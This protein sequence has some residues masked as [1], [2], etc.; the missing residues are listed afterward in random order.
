MQSSCFVKSFGTVFLLTILVS[1]QNTEKEEQAL[2]EVCQTLNLSAKDFDG[3]AAGKLRELN[4]KLI[5][6][7]LKERAEIWFPKAD[8]INKLSELSVK[9]I[10][11]LQQLIT[12]DNFE[13]VVKQVADIYQSY[14]SKVLKT[15]IEI[16]K[17]FQS[18][19]GKNN[20]FQNF[21][22]HSLAQLFF[23]KVKHDISY[24]NERTIDY[25]NIKTPPGCILDFT[26]SQTLVGQS[27]TILLPGEMLEISAGVGRFSAASKPQIKINK[28]N[29]STDDNPVATTKIKVPQK[30]GHYTV[31]VEISYIDENGETI[32]QDYNIKYKVANLQE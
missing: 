27:S 31:P 20:N 18:E 23:Y 12:K 1:C 11:S 7:R 15:D 17:V 32:T 28:R 10:D 5:D 9:Q 21:N 8:T 24:I 14:V 29:I 6:Y 3:V 25:C 16:N 19:T 13:S 4:N 2:K 30:P 26:M 22:S